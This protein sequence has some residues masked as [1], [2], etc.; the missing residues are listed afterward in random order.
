MRRS[1]E[2]GVTG[3][4]CFVLPSVPGRC[5][6]WVGVSNDSDQLQGGLDWQGSNVHVADIRGLANGAVY[7][8]MGN[9]IGSIV[10]EGDKNSCT[11]SIKKN[12]VEYQNS[13][14]ALKTYMH[15][16]FGGFLASENGGSDMVERPYTFPILGEKQR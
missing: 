7:D 5:E 6:I 11:I 12:S 9:I 16:I 14:D 13:W 4:P 3:V 2:L 15:A 10:R 8:R 1:R